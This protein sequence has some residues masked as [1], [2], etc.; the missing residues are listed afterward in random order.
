M[1]SVIYIVYFSYMKYTSAGGIQMEYLTI[2]EISPEWKISKRMVAYYC[3]SGRIHGAIKK[4]KTWLIPQ[5]AEK[6]VDKRFS[7]KGIRSH[8]S[9]ALKGEQKNITEKDIENI[10]NVYH[11]RD[12]YK[13][14]GLTRET[15]RYY[16]EIG[17]INPKRNPNSQYRNFDFFDIS[18]LMAI[19][20]FKKRG[21]SPLEVKKLMNITNI[22]NYIKIMTQQIEYFEENI[23]HLQHIVKKL[24]LTTNFC[25]HYLEDMN[26]FT[27]KNIQLYSVQ[28]TIDVISSFGEYR[29]K[30][31][32]Y[33]D[34]EDED[35]LSNLVRLITFDETGYKGSEMCIVKPAAKRN[36]NETYYLEDGRCLYTTLS[37]DN[38]DNS[39]MDKMFSLAHEW[40]KKNNEKF[41][42]IVYIFIRF[43]MLDER[44][45]QN[46]YEI[47]IPLK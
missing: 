18:H 2:A 29:D 21:F 19:D 17:L 27:V 14:L 31:L 22:E 13:N 4:G 24:H 23:R 1:N 46:F 3:E 44:T 12:V 43:I 25:V 28:E 45:E 30:V 34:L 42:G 6:P 40:A 20:F 37:A 35:I 15:L 47:W 9:K 26:Q 41:R 32:M 38:N 10:G 33:L 11:A 39:I 5:D 36:Q 8:Y 7:R 16:E